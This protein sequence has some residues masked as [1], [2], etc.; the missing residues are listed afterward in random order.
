LQAGG[1]GFRIHGKEAERNQEKDGLR[2]T[3]AGR[4]RG[5]EGKRREHDGMIPGLDVWGAVRRG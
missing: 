1:G 5:K 3:H 4:K 2:K